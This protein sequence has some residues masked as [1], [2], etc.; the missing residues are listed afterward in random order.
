MQLEFGYCHTINS[1]WAGCQQ[2]CSLPV[3]SNPSLPIVSI[4]QEYATSHVKQEYQGAVLSLLPPPKTIYISI[5]KA[6]PVVLTT[7]P[8]TRP[9]NTLSPFCV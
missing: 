8:G 4:V 6:R 1:A 9:N 7:F 5:G 2:D 3:N